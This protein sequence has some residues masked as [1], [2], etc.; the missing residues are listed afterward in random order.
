MTNLTFGFDQPEAS[1]G[2]LL[3]QTTI[4]W[5]R[6]IKK[7]RDVYDLSHPQFVILAILL[8]FQEKKEES[9]QIRIARLSKL[10]KMTVS[11]SLKKL[12]ALGLVDRSEHKQDTSAKSVVLTKKGKIMAMKLVPI[13]EQIDANYFG[14]LS[15]KEEAS[16]IGALANL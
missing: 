2:F 8:W 10:D 12:V 7:A 3:W 13:V 5:Q 4:T 1:P 6:L 11:K 14:Q 9:N 15:H 16:L